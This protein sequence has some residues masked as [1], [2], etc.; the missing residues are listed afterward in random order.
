MVTAHSESLIAAL[1]QLRDDPNAESEIGV[2]R[3][4]DRFVDTARGQWFTAAEMIFSLK[5]H[6]ARAV[7]RSP[8]DVRGPVPPSAIDA[9]VQ[10]C[11]TQAVARYYHDTP[12]RQA[13]AEE[14]PSAQGSR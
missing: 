6:V 7:A 14:S 3:E 1:Q 12:S 5:Y 4:V 10:E 13:P 11:V 2:R 9:R 8:D